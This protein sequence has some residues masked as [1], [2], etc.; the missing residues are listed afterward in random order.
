MIYLDILSRL[1]RR[2]ADEE[3]EDYGLD[4]GEL[5]FGKIGKLEIWILVIRYDNNEEEELPL[6]IKTDY[7]LITLIKISKK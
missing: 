2:V 3:I 5:S 4:N 1:R 7:Y 6:N